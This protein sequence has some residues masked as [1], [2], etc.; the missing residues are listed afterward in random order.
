M[1]ARLGEQRLG[2]WTECGWRDEE[3]S[4]YHR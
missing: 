4:R 2:E 1:C 3:G